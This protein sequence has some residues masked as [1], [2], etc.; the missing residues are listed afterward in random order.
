MRTIAII[1][2]KGGCGKT[3]T[4]INLAGVFSRAGVRTLLVDLDPQAHCAAGLAIPEQRID[5]SI[6]DALAACDDKPID[7]TRLLWR[8]SRNLD[9]APSTVRLAGLEAARGGLSHL[10]NPERRLLSVLSRLADQYDIC[11]LDCPPAIGLLTYNALVA[12]SD[13]LIPVETSFF[14]LQGAAK[15]VSAIKSLGKRLGVAPPYRILP[16]LHNDQSTLSRDLLGELQRRFEGRVS[17]VVIRFD[18]HLREA[19]SFGQPVVEYAPHAPGAEDYVALGRWLLD[20]R[21][22]QPVLPASA[23]ALDD[24]SVTVREGA[25]DSFLGGPAQLDAHPPAVA[26]G[27]TP[28]ETLPTAEAIRS[29]TTELASRVAKLV[30]RGE[31]RPLAIADVPTLTTYLRAAGRIETPGLAGVY[32]VR[33]TRQGVLFVQPA[34]LGRSIAVAGTFNNWSPDQHPLRLNEQLGVYET[35]IP[36]PP[37]KFSYRLVIDGQWRADPHNA[38]TEANP[39]GGINSILN[40]SGTPLSVSA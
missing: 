7:W 2:Q 32:G 13:V 10:P 16:T 30:E 40:V 12:A 9:L 11:L 5:I 1:N 6:G 18:Q 24:S 34:S 27:P 15:Q 28:V 33:E 14:S 35:C 8:V 4:A 17:P 23:P 26:P 37:G 20:A 25:A 3:T 22:L 36:L 21:E 38:E 29:R 31:P 39:F 19:V